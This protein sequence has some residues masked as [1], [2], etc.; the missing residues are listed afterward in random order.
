M[1]R[2][3]PKPRQPP[4]SDSKL[5]GHPRPSDPR[6]EEWVIDEAEDE[7]FPASDPSSVTQPHRPRKKKIP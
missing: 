2:K 4:V 6:H 1:K 3:K 5:P 7:S